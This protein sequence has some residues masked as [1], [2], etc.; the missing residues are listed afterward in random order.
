MAVIK[1]SALSGR[2]P[3]GMESM[4]R[5]ALRVFVIS[6]SL[7]ATPRLHIIEKAT[8]IFKIYYRFRR[9][10]LEGYISVFILLLFLFIKP[11][12][13]RLVFLLHI[14]LLPQSIPVVFLLHYIEF[15][16][17]SSHHISIRRRVAAEGMVAYPVNFFQPYRRIQW[18]SHCY[19]RD[20]LSLPKS[21]LIPPHPPKYHK[22]KLATRPWSNRA[23]SERAVFY[24][25]LIFQHLYFWT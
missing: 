1:N 11:L 21:H 17:P 25:A 23:V 14:S 6:R 2:G 13:S 5:Q 15:L 4:V 24:L 7:G 16:L 3:L 10:G 18:R 8:V 12:N 9:K 22:I 20:P 19:R